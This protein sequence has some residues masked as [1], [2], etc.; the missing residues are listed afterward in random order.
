MSTTFLGSPLIGELLAD[1]TTFKERGRAYQ[2]LEEYFAGLPIDTLRPL[3]AHESVLVR[4]AAVWVASELGQEACVLLD[5]VVQLIASDDRFLTYHAL[6]LTVVCAIGKHVDR[7][8]HVPLVLES[9]DD[10]IQVLTMRLLARADQTQLEAGARLTETMGS[11][12]EVHR[13][14]LSLLANCQSRDPEDVR[15]MLLEDDSVARM[16]GAIA[17]RRLHKASPELL[18]MAAELS[19]INVSRFARE[20]A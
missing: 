8:I 19:D 4:H 20:A 16:Y 14:G 12:G 3:L 1:P 18:Q 7:F 11:I 10:V 9:S 17:A 2:L 13:R 15:R 5:D 6:E